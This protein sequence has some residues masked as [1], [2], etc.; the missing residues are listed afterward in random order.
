V[1]LLAKVQDEA[2]HGLYLYAAAETLGLSREEMVISCSPASQVLL[3]LQL[4]NP[5]RADIGAVGWS[6][7]R[8][9]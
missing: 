5:V 7:G 6:K 1:A 8:R 2:G 9:S 4:S 3:D